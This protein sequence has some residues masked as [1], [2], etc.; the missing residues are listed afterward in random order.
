MSDL[1]LTD[2]ETKVI[3]FLTTRGDGPIHWEELAQFAKDPQTVKLKTIQKVISDLKRK[4]LQANVPFP[5]NGKFISLTAPPKEEP[6]APQT[7]GEL[8][9][10]K[11]AD[12]PEQA[13]VQI[14][15]TPAGTVVRVDPANS[16]KPMAHVDFVLD[17]NTRRVR[18]KYGAHLLN[19]REWDVMKYLHANVGRVIAISELRDKVVYEKYGSKL[20]PRWFDHIKAIIGNLRAQVPGLRDRV[21]TVKG[22]ETSYLFQ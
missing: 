8:I 5:Y 6:K 1:K 17:P 19:E 10:E 15:R 18:T 20:P 9:K 11:L 2:Q 12:K 4:Y 21:L 14:K 16:G 7:I 3:A 13:L 22:V